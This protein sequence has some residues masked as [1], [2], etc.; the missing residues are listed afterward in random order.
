MGHAPSAEPN[1]TIS[2]RSLSVSLDTRSLAMTVKDLRRGKQWVQGPD[3]TGTMTLEVVRR[4][5]EISATWMEPRSARILQGTWRLEPNL[6]ELTLTL[7]GKGELDRPLA[8]PPAFVTG[9]D[10]MLVIP[11]NEGIS[12]PADDPS[13][14][15]R[16]LV[17]YG[18]HGICMAFWAV[19]DGE[20]SQMAIIETPDDAA[21]R[22]QRSADRLCVQP[23]WDAQKG[24]FGYDRRLRYVF[25]DRG[26]YVAACKRYRAYA[27]EHGLVKTLSQKRE[28]IEAVDLLVGINVWNWDMDPVQIVRQMMALGMDRILWSRASNTATVTALNQIGR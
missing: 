2:S 23:E 19:T 5:T 6:A 18:G 10:T 20:A 8:F 9:P 17:A 16:R 12:V 1:V 13:F 14:D 3:S 24:Q 26:G 15:T 28:E 21:I 7:T 22:L 11:M 25:L 4:D 27:R